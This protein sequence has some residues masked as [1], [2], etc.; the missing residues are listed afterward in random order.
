MPGPI[1]EP[2]SIIVSELKIRA[3][4]AFTLRPLEAQPRLEPC[5]CL[6]LD[7]LLP[8]KVSQTQ[9]SN[10]RRRHQKGL[11][12]ANGGGGG[13]QGTCGQSQR[14]R[15]QGATCSQRLGLSRCSPH[16]SCVAFSF[17]G[18]SSRKEDK[19][20]PSASFWELKS[21]RRAQHGA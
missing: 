15:A 17:L 6:P 10:P 12:V 21:M 2:W 5:L 18:F 13:G 9:G 20:C 1:A 8:L 7:T 11:G 19:S 3:E 16:V 4:Q 14:W